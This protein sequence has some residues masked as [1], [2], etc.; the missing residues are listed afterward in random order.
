MTSGALRCELEQIGGDAGDVQAGAQRFFEGDGRAVAEVD[1]LGG[2]EPGEGEPFG[3]ERGAV[4]RPDAESIPGVVGESAVAGVEGELPDLLPGTGQAQEPVADEQGGEWRCLGVADRCGGGW[5]R[6]DGTGCC[7]C[8]SGDGRSVGACWD[9]LSV[10]CCCQG[11]DDLVEPLLGGLFEVRLA[12]E[13]G[14]S[15]VAPRAS[16]RSSSRRPWPQKSA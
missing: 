12:V 9:G 10:G 2:V 14:I 1:R 13:A 7:A 6:G 11:G 4:G 15:L 5:R 8:G 16:N 3:D